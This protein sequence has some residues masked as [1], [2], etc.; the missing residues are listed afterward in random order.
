MRAYRH[1]SLI[2][3][4]AYRRKVHFACQHSCG[5]A[6]GRRGERKKTFSP[7]YQWK[8][9]LRSWTFL[10]CFPMWA[11]ETCTR[12]QLS[13]LPH[14]H[15]V[16]L[17]IEFGLH[18][19]N[20]AEVESHKE[21]FC[22]STPLWQIPCAEMSKINAIFCIKWI[23]LFCIGQL[24]ERWIMGHDCSWKSKSYATQLCRSVSWTAVMP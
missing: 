2:S 13:A 14:L 16:L 5:A 3:S 4:V 19:G 9:F 7:L 6:T 8:R 20:C 23:K 10:S 24:W 15:V 1:N 11:A 21:N 17:S 22:S 18:F 12:L